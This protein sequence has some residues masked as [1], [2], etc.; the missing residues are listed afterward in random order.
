M[1]KTDSKLFQRSKEY[2][3]SAKLQDLYPGTLY[4]FTEN[5]ESRFKITKFFLRNESSQ[6]LLC[7]IT[8]LNNQQLNEIRTVILQEAR[9][10]VDPNNPRFEKLIETLILFAVG[11]KHQWFHD[12]ESNYRTKMK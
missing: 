6:A 3:T 11:D 4:K 7:D 1:K 10:I 5:F 12:D 9:I 2:Q 8:K